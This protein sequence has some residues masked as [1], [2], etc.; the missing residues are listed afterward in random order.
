[1]DRPFLYQL[2]SSKKDSK[3][4]ADFL[5]AL[6]K[7]GRRYGRLDGVFPRD[8]AYLRQALDPELMG[9]FH[10]LTVDQTISSTTTHTSGLVYS[11]ER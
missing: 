7:Y 3:G 11:E 6:A 4:T 5:T 8:I 10:Y 9:V 1:M 2:D